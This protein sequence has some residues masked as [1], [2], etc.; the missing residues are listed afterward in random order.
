MAND[1]G[2][3]CCVGPLEHRGIGSPFPMTTTCRT[4][5]KDTARSSH[6]TYGKNRVPPKLPEAYS[7]RMNSQFPERRS[8]TRRTPRAYEQLAWAGIASPMW[9]RERA[10]RWRRR[11]LQLKTK[12]AEAAR[13]DGRR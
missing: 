5:H 10:P 2:C 3:N 7:C 9:A 1:D 12:L 13:I 11:Q 8:I 6:Q 4:F